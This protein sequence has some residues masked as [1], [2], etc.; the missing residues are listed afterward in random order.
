MKPL[1][2]SITKWKSRVHLCCSEMLG[3][4][5][6]T[7]YNE[8]YTSILTAHISQNLSKLSNFLPAENK[9][10]AVQEPGMR[11][12]FPLCGSSW[13]SADKG[14]PTLYIFIFLTT[15]PPLLHGAMKISAS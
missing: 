13:S 15:E 11:N 6:I 14:P 3:C 1:Y 4:S 10:K 9:R 12:A 2:F 7:S 8:E 5:I